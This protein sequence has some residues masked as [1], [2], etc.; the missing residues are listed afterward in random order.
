MC[1]GRVFEGKGWKEESD[2]ASLTRGTSI[3]LQPTPLCLVFFEKQ[4]EKSH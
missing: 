3:S 4:E 1:G 2:T